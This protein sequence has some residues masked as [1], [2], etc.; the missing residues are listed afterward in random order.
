MPCAT[1]GWTTAFTHA[2]HGELTRAFATQPV[3]ALFA[4]AVAALAIVS[5]YGLAMGA[6][7][8]PFWRW[9]WQ[10]RHVLLL[11]VMVLTAWLYKI[12]TMPG[13]S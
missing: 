4:V 10:P 11:A 2:V 1:C 9:L 13:A 5:G 8:T 6:S 3:G 12:I 7:L